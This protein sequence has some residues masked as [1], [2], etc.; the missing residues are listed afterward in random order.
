MLVHLT[1]LRKLL[2]ALIALVFYVSYL[3]VESVL[4]ID[5]VDTFE[6]NKLLNR[7][8]TSFKPIESLPSE[9]ENGRRNLVVHVGPPKTGTTSLQTDLSG[10]M[11]IL[12]QDG[13]EY[14]GRF[15]KPSV[16]SEGKSALNRRDSLLQ[17]SARSMFK[18][19]EEI[20]RSKCAN[21]FLQELRN[22][23]GSSVIVSEESLSQWK[24]SDVLA[25]R[26]AMVA[27]KWNVTIVVTY[28]H[29]FE[30][31]PSAKFQ[32][33]RI[34]RWA[35][36]KSNWPGEGPGKNGRPLDPLFP[37]YFR[38]WRNYHVFCDVLIEFF[39]N[40]F[41][42][43]TLDIHDDTSLRTS[44]LCSIP[45]ASKS[46][47][48]SQRLD[49]EKEETH[50]NLQDD[51]PSS[52][53]DAVATAAAAKGFL[54]TSLVERRFVACDIMLFQKQILKQT[55]LDFPLKCP[56]KQQQS[57][58]LEESVL[59]ETKIFSTTFAE[60]KIRQ[61]KELGE[62]VAAKGFCWVDSDAVL[63]MHEWNTYFARYNDSTY[64]KGLKYGWRCEQG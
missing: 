36:F 24:E 12:R 56:T 43:V 46:C 45:H 41:P 10:F 13:Y 19:C 17:G 14:A 4:S 50:M 7:R 15:Y 62:R 38:E 27:D 35:A 22:Y 26:D 21:E 59:L 44:F 23:R 8:T 3:N 61:R 2:I 30:W 25:F 37:S 6:R 42:V 54:D 34:D 52:F 55:A 33:E 18:R 58:F 31:L 63:D 32:R 57:I 60:N 16:N 20:P 64:A 28:R 40:A 1:S 51:T 11:E 53:Y 48:E 49:R 39:Q 5:K 9:Q 47:Q 29:L